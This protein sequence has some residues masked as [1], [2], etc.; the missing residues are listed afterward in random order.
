MD[1]IWL[2]FASCS[3]LNSSVFVTLT[4]DL[5]ETWGLSLLPVCPSTTVEEGEGCM[6]RK[7]TVQVEFKPK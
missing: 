1:P 5:F 2:K 3:S 4:L 6:K 7:Q